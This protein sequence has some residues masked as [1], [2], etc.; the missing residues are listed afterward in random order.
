[1]SKLSTRHVYKPGTIIH[2]SSGVQRHV[3]PKFSGQLPNSPIFL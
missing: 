1:M 2:I 3:L